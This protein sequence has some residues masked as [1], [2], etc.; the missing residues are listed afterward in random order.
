MEQ[1]KI[2]YGIDILEKLREKGIKSDIYLEKGKAKK[3]FSYAD[4]LGVNC[5]IVIGAREEKEKLVTFKD[6]ETGKQ[7]LYR[8][9][10]VIQM[11]NGGKLCL[12]HFQ[13]EIK[14][15]LTRVQVY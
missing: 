4:K 3:K 8:I 13:M 14:K 9:E 5:T 6:F 15:N 12:L 2:D 10:E 1:E 11:L 7:D